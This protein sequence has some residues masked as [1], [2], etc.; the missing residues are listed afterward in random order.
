MGVVFKALDQKLDEVVALKFLRVDPT[1]K[2]L[3]PTDLERVAALANRL[4]SEIKLAWRVRHRNVCGIHEYGEDGDLLFISMEFV[5]GRDLRRTLREKALLWEEAYD[6][7]LQVADG[8][9]AIHDAGIIH[10]DLKPANI[11][12]DAK[13]V[14]RL[15]DFGIAK[16]WGAESG[17]GLTES[18]HIVGSPEYM[19][20]EQVLDRALDFRSD[21]YTFGVVL[22]EL[23]T[24]RVPKHLH[25]P[26]PLDGP[27]A[28]R[29][30]SAL[31]PIL[32]C[33]LTK[34]PDGRYST[35]VELK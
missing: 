16:V 3:G 15:M 32:K 9:A 33:A 22:F 17:A 20:P 14:V 2:R 5:D 29:I 31:L 12:L 21:L 13:G 19:S 7:A 34:E 26:P 28:E 30:P 23:F 8:L 35:C 24:G 10:R 18:G 25:A 27:Q 6:V 11:M 4:R 1:R